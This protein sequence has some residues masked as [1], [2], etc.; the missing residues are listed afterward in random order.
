MGRVK[1]KL[2]QGSKDAARKLGG[3]DPRRL[4]EAT[5]F[6]AVAGLRSMTAP[7]QVARRLSAINGNKDRGNVVSRA[8]ANPTIARG[9]GLGALLELAADKMPFM[10][11]RVSALPLGG[12]ALMGAVAAVA[13]SRARRPAEIA[14]VAILGGA[15]AV[16]ASYLAYQLR[17]RSSAQR[18]RLGKTLVGLAEDALTLGLAQLCGGARRR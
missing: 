18:G 1:L 14:T 15:A 9:L 5:A 11:A 7:A 13:W 17:M 10:P 2:V 16:G 4:L 12:R 6:G 3:H 8:L